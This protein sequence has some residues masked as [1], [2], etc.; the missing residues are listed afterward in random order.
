MKINNLLMLTIILCIIS[1]FAGANSVG[2]YQICQLKDT[3]GA[4]TFE[5]G[6]DRTGSVKKPTE[7]ST[8]CSNVFEDV[9]G[10]HLLSIKDMHDNVFVYR[11][12]MPEGSFTKFE[13]NSPEKCSY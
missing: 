12:R 2:K 9:G 4:I 8:H 3:H 7:V 1:T 11:A 5:Q 13:V 10:G 6:P